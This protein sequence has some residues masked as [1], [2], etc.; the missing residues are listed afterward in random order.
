MIALGRQRGS[1]LGRQPERLGREAEVGRCEQAVLGDLV[2]FVSRS[3]EESECLREHESLLSAALA[4]NVWK[5]SCLV[6]KH[7][8]SDEKEPCQHPDL[9][10]VAALGQPPRTRNGLC[11]QALRSLRRFAHLLQKHLGWRVHAASSSARRKAWRRNSA[12]LMPLAS[13][14]RSASSSTRLFTRKCALVS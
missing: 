9:S 7:L 8:R 6:L 1:E 10:E 13:A 3:I 4:L 2:S 12:R 11:Q 14:R 5:E